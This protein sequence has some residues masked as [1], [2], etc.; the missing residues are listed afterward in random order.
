MQ[1]KALTAH[2]YGG[3]PYKPG[4]KYEIKGKSDLRLYKALGRVVEDSTPVPVEQPRNTYAT[5][6]MEADAP[7]R[8]FAP[9]AAKKVAAKKV[10]TKRATSDE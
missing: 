1:V 6:M 2:R 7:A 10:A 9:P 3:K 8:T 5:R 4:A